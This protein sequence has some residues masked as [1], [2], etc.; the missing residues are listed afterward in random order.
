MGINACSCVDNLK[1]IDIY[2]GELAHRGQTCCWHI[3]LAF[4]LQL[5]LSVKCMERAVSEA[6]S[7]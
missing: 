3:H 2:K 4:D 6:C 1:V 7:V 5:P